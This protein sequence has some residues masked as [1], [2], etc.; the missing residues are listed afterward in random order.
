METVTD[1]NRWL[2]NLKHR[3]LDSV[4]C[5]SLRWRKVFE[6]CLLKSVRSPRIFSSL[7]FRS[8]SPT[9]CVRRF[10]E[11]RNGKAWIALPAGMSRCPE[12]SADML[13]EQKPCT[14]TD[15][16]MKKSLFDSCLCVVARTCRIDVLVESLLVARKQFVRYTLASPF[17]F[18]VKVFW[19][20]SISEF[21]STTTIFY[22]NLFNLFILQHLT[23]KL[24]GQ[25]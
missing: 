25:Y 20:K 15:R 24:M 22:R 13:S 17:L 4:E 5:Q 1:I 21:K 2:L 14:D 16:N 9:C 8:H 11:Y 6:L 7:D 12:D 10:R 23:Y 3:L 18:L 19:P